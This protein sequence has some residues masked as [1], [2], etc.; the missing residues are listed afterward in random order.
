MVM[1]K[2]LNTLRDPSIASGSMSWEFQLLQWRDRSHEFFVDA[3]GG[4]QFS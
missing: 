2:L 1:E 4:K 3:T